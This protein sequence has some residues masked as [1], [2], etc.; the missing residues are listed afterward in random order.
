M[1]RCHAAG[2][3]K[4]TPPTIRGGPRCA[5][6]RRPIGPAGAPSALPDPSLLHARHRLLVPPLG[7]RAVGLVGRARRGGTAHLGRGP[8]RAPSVIGSVVR[9]GGQR[10]GRATLVVT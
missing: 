10:P 3:G 9:G 5:L 1:T 2:H 8:A 4:A 6:K 7:G